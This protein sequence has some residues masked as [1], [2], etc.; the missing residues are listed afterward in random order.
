MP[1]H[2]LFRRLADYIFKTSIVLGEIFQ[3]IAADMAEMLEV[4]HGGRI[5]CNDRQNLALGKRL[6]RLL[7]FQDRKRAA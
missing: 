2:R 6:E 4:N 5:R 7:G 1:D 3:H